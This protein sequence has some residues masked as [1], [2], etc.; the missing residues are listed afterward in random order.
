[1][2]H[3][4][5]SSDWAVRRTIRVYCSL[6]LN[7]NKSNASAKNTMKIHTVPA[8]HNIH[9]QL[10]FR[11]KFVLSYGNFGRL[12]TAQYHSRNLKWWQQR[13]NADGRFVCGIRTYGTHGGVAETPSNIC[14]HSLYKKTVVFMSNFI[15][16]AYTNSHTQ[17]IGEITS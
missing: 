11:F 9:T 5:F 2:V 8:A 12:Q 14:A 13:W 17:R 16:S 10:L 15:P 6:F 3:Y 1:M 7:H 4:F